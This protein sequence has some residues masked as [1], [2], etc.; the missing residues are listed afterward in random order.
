MFDG[1]EGVKQAVAEQVNMQLQDAF[2]VLEGVFD[3]S[4]EEQ[5]RVT[6]ADIDNL[7]QRIIDSIDPSAPTDHPVYNLVRLSL[8]LKARPV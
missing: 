3:V 5:E 8:V 1:E 2:E 6:E 7:M 4:P